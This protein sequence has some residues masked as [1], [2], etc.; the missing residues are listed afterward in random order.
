MFRPGVTF[1][2]HEEQE[3]WVRKWLCEAGLNKE[4]ERL[5]LVSHAEVF[6]LLVREVGSGVAISMGE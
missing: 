6:R 4:S 3:E 5:R 2:S 1:E